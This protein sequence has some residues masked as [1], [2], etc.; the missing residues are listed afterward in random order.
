ML[1]KKLLIILFTCLSLNIFSQNSG[2]F[3]DNR[4]DQVY[5]WVKIGSQT[6]MA[7]NLNYNSGR[8][9]G[10]YS[11]IYGRV[12]NWETAKMICPNGW[13][14]PSDNEWLTLEYYMGMSRSDNEDFD[15]YKTNEWNG[16]KLLKSQKGWQ[17]YMQNGNGLDSYGFSA[18]PGGYYQTHTKK[19]M[20]YGS[21]ITFWTCTE[22]DALN[23]I[24]RELGSH[25]DG[26]SNLEIKKVHGA[27][28]RCIKD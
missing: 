28:C 9:S 26:I 17:F 27:Y 2:S 5:K 14:L 8:S 13:H 4:D 12:Y 3:N 20:Y 11:N 7:E 15:Y 6:W 16:G 23:A 19:F 24:A 25:Y 1:L 21:G 18:L 22:V 10:K